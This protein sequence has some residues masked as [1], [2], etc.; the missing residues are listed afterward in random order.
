MFPSRD[1]FAY[2]FP[3]GKDN[4]ARGV[5]VML[6]N[7]YS[8][9]AGRGLSSNAARLREPLTTGWLEQMANAS[10]NTHRSAFDVVQ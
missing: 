8:I 4:K 9:L 5:V 2:I 3:Q 1:G 7:T 6:N 10:I